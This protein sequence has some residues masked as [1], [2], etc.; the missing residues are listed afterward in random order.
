[1]LQPLPIWGYDLANLWIMLNS[2]SIRNLRPL[3]SLKFSSG[4]R[5]EKAAKT[6][7]NTTALTNSGMLTRLLRCALN[8]PTIL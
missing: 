7:S 5:V 3:D 4:I 2:L 8:K 1:M 6:L